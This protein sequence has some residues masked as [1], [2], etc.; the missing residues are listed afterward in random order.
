MKEEI[1]K[2]DNLYNLN[3]IDSPC[4]V[5]STGETLTRGLSNVINAHWSDS[6]QEAGNQEQARKWSAYRLPR[7]VMQTL[8]AIT[9]LFLMLSVSN[10]AHAQIKPKIRELDT[11][12]LDIDENIK[13]TG[14]NPIYSTESMR[15]DYGKYTKGKEKDIINA[16][17]LK[18]GISELHATVGKSQ[19]VRFDEPVVQISITNPELIDIRPLSSTKEFL[20]S[21]KQGGETT[22]IIWGESGEPVFFNLF[23][24]NDNYKIVDEIRKLAPNENLDI[25]FIDSGRS[26][27]LQVVLKG[28]L[29][30]SI[31]RE[32][33]DN[34]IKAYGH[35][36]VD[37]TETL[38]PQVLLE[39]RIVE[40]GK[41]KNKNRG[42]EFKR[43][44]FDYLNLAESA[45]GNTVNL[46][47]GGEELDNPWFKDIAWSLLGKGGVMGTPKG[48]L[49]QVEKASLSGMSYDGNGTLGAWKAIP[50]SN[51][52]YK[53][54]AAE[55]EG[56]V[57]TLSEPRVMVVNKHQAT[58]NSGSQIP[59][60]TGTDE[61][62]NIQ[63]EYT[64]IGTQ[65][66]ITP[67]ILE[68]SERILLDISATV[69]EIDS[70]IVV[71]GGPGLNTRESKTKVEIANNATT[72]ITG[73]VRK[74]E[75]K[76][77]TKLPMLS[78]LPV[79]GNLFNNISSSND[80]TELMIFV[81]ASIVKPDLV[82]GD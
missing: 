55:S 35:K 9:T 61:L 5:S 2:I 78:N 82:K 30:S 60:P 46:F 27:G 18:G 66:S 19:I 38:E 1:E 39:V 21:G 64:N 44:L 72:V 53:L 67:T 13:N 59:I 71:N 28:R 77:I 29:S 73:L 65:I 7:R 36:M 47:L 37:L 26:T 15:N 20:V 81:T 40:L 6:A 74:S 70:S 22:V 48:N 54:E 80:D 57:K 68:E 12:V 17:V 69:S 34:I 63:Y 11:N 16:P 3:I 25:D 42:Y 49:V 75:S 62:G 43:G 10:Y 23:V 14:N 45:S 8:L 76:T 79:V 31:L 50:G 32:K 33:I 51:L 52:A 56:I 4:P 24:D 58:F 41:S